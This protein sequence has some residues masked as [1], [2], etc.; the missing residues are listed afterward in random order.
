MMRPFPFAKSYRLVGA[1]LVFLLVSMNCN[2][3]TP[4]TAPA[5]TANPQPTSAFPPTEQ[6]PQPTETSPQPTEPP[7]PTD[8]PQATF[9]L[10]RVSAAVLA[11]A[12]DPLSEIQED[13]PFP[14]PEGSFV[15]VNTSGEALLAGSLE[16]ISCKI[17]VFFDTRLQKKACEKSAFTGSNVS[18]IEEGSAIFDSCANMLVQTP[19]AEFQLK[20]TWILA[21][22]LSEYQLSVLSV[23]DGLVDARPVT[24]AASYS[25]GEAQPVG[26]GNF[27][28][29]APDEMLS[30]VQVAGIDMRQ[31]VPWESLSALVR[32]YHLER[33]YDRGRDHAGE[34]NV[35]FPSEDQVAGPPD[36]ITALESRPQTDADLDIMRQNPDFIGV[37]VRVTVSNQGGKP[38]DPFK[39]SVNGKGSDGEYVRAFTVQGQ[40]DLWYP[41]TTE[42]L[43]PGNEIVFDGV[44]LFPPALNG[45]EVTLTAIADSCSG[46][47]FVPPEC[48]I[49]ESDE[50]NNTSEPLTVTLPIIIGAVFSP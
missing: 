34:S 26:A 15:Q 16:G 39:I 5:A 17:F 1:F 47:E 49:A 7:A 24:D 9:S 46:E 41:H 50:G 8:T 45:Q 48:H 27:L 6:P 44:V 30:Q 20:G 11:G 42:P 43:E 40:E 2:L 38:A 21:T 25:T 3:L 4:P 37:P 23:S 14:F 32:Q 19:S 29:T 10:Q 36:L 13:G 28:Y 33:W 12:A 22:Y 18:C 31:A 35:P